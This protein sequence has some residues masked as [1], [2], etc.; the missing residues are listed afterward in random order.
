MKQNLNKRKRG[1]MVNMKTDGVVVSVSAIIQTFCGIVQTTEVFQLISVILGTLTGL[2]TLAYFI[3]R[4]WTKA[5]EDKKITK[6]EVDE[7]L[8][9]ID[10]IINKKKDD[11]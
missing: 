10:D 11:E 7:L 3:W 4:W 1:T 5:T 2:F 8:Q 9:G 6:E